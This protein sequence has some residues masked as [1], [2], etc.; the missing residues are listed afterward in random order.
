MGGVPYGVRWN[1]F[2]RDVEDAVP[3]GVRW[4]PMWRARLSD[5]CDSTEKCTILGMQFVGTVAPTVRCGGNLLVFGRPRAVVPTW[6]CKN[7][8]YAHRMNGMYGIVL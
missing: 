3:Y 7:Y 5:N 4:N 6:V 1:V 2:G 8:Q